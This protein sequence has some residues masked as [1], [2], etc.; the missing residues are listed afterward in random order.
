MVRI[1]AIK[2]KSLQCNRR[3]NL[4]LQAVLLQMSVLVYKKTK[5]TKCNKR[6]ACS[7]SY[8]RFALCYKDV[9]IFPK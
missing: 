4:A 8:S 9:W 6:T 5:V 7:E 2:I 1:S 3:Q